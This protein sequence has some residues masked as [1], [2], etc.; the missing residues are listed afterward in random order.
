MDFNRKTSISST[1]QE[2]NPQ[3]L[4]I[5][6]RD[7]QKGLKRQK[8]VKLKAVVDVFARAQGLELRIQ[9]CCSREPQKTMGS[10]G[11]LVFNSVNMGFI[12]V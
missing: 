6:N 9:A 11:V 8:R 10:L 3:F 7:P 4:Y 5:F 12:K 2:G 1:F